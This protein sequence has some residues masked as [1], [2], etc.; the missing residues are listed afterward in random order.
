M[1]PASQAIACSVVLPKDY[2]GSARQ[3]REVREAITQ[4]PAI[5]DG[6]VIRPW[7]GGKPALVRIHHVLKGK[8]AELI[9]VGGPGAGGDCSL[10]LEWIGERRRMI[11]SGGPN[12]YDL[13][14]DGSEARLEDRILKSDRRKIW[15][16]SPGQTNTGR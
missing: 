4:S 5:V 2:E 8:V 1:L 16:Y 13:F 3:R 6:E 10:A 11:L 14:R 12:L 9:E 15:P 7:F